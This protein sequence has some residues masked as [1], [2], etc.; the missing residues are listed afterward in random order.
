MPL[1]VGSRLGHYDVTALIG[2]GGMGQVYQ[3][4]D[5]K[6][7]RQVALKILPEAFS[8]DP[9]RLARFQR[10]A[11]VLA[12][13]NHPNIAA[14]HGLEEAEGIR[15]LV[16]E[17]VEGPTLADRIKQGP[18]PLDEA[19]PI[20]KQIA[21]A[22]EAAHEKGIIHRDLKPA[23]IKV[24]EDGTV[25]VLD[26]GLAKALDPSPTGDPS[27][28]PTLTAMATQM[29]VIM[30]TAAYM[31]PEQA[32]GKTVDKR[33]D[34]W[35]FGCVLYEMLTGQMAFQGEDV[36]LTLA[37]VMKSDL[38]V[39][40][41]RPDVPATVRT[42]L[43][44][45]L[46]KDASKRIRDIG[47][48]SLAMEGAFE[49]RV[50][51]PS[52][53]GVVLQLQ[54]WQRPIPLALA[55]LG[56]A[57]IASLGVWT[58]TRPEPPP[59]SL[60]ARFPIPLAADQ[61]F[62]HIGRPLVAISPDGTQVVYV[63][64]NSLWLRP[65]D[66]LQAT[67]VPGTE[68]EARGPFFSADGQS[69][70]FWADGQLKKVSVSGGAP[71]T[72]ADV[73]TNPYG[74]SWGADDMILYGQPDGIMQVPGASGTPEL[75]IPADRDED[76]YGPQML[77]G[78]EWVLFT[79]RA[80]G[81]SWEEAQIV[82]QSVTTAERTVLIER[83][84]DGRYLPTGHLVYL[85]NNVLFAV[86]F[87]IG[88]R[89][90]TGGPV[91]LVEGVRAAVGG[92]QGGGAAQFSVSANGSLVYVPGSAGGN[93]VTL[94]W[95]G[96]DGDEEL[97]SAPPRAYGRPRVSPDGTRVAVDITDGDN[98]DI[99]IWDLA[100]ETLTQL[101]FDEA[102]DDYA[103]WTPDSAR[104][105]FTSSREGGGLFWKAADGT[106]QVERLKDGLARPYAWATDGRLIFEE[107]Q[108][109]GVLTME[110]ER[111]EEMLLDAEFL[112]AVPALSPDGR[113][114]AYVS[115]ETG[116]PLIYVQPFPNLDGLW[117][118]SLDFGVN[119]VWSPDGRGLFYRGPTGTD[120]M[121][122]QVETEPTFSHRTPEPLFS[123]S[124]YAVGSG[125]TEARVFDLAP[126]GDRFIFRRTGTAAQTSDLNGLIFVEH[127]FEELTARVPVN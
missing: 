55:V 11:E 41:L 98:R 71:V 56:I 10:E 95:V 108:D 124:G 74:A 123:L 25:K 80:D 28:S 107:G 51:A 116:S 62:N 104:V 21:E 26:F 8:A 12:S 90:V 33:A 54:L 29:G 103:L 40:R 111:T 6:L 105:V 122:A 5:T 76:I 115:G 24:R 43:R 99:W 112:E 84:R 42:V 23:N 34:I 32:R 114:L 110:G 45:C 39:T 91:P 69:L 126:D 52:E 57:A 93:V 59:P 58:L 38:N 97:I 27:Q 20:A 72:L 113:W 67:Q 117:N 66:Q 50:S 7:K 49:T 61:V 65:V 100:R 119:P 120:L 15:A 106:G 86:P 83:G 19:L 125:P 96:R 13:L 2:E 87:D 53:A 30:G 22:L 78:G 89:E 36:S 85:L 44:R 47:D 46:E 18:I 35:A 101:T 82:T 92:G 68:E 81:V 127:W 1:N 73:P 102:D 37:S 63:A 31:S 109:I 9:E 48:V 3:A 16:L 88:S 94:T 77:P 64:N 17:L 75:L 118:V 60:V 70:G 4:T 79:V 14:I 121:V